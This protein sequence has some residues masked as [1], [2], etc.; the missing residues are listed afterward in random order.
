MSKNKRQGDNMKKI[1]QIRFR[2]ENVI[3][4]I[5]R[6]KQS[7]H[8][9]TISFNPNELECRLDI[10]SSYIDTAMSLQTDLV[11]YDPTNDD[12]ANL[13]DICVTTKSLF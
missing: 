3:K 7:E 9:K 11:L 1:Y 5:Q 6:I 2:Q 10:L 8:G 13:K 4:S 12:R